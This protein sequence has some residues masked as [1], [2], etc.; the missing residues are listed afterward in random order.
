MPVVSRLRYLPLAVAGVM[1]GLT[2]CGGGNNLAD[3][4]KEVLANCTGDNC[5]VGQ[6]LDEPV[7]GLNY[8]CD[9][10]VSVTSATGTFSCPNNSVATFYLKAK[11]GKREIVL[12]SV[13]ISRIV[14]VTGFQAVKVLQITP[15]D[16]VDNGR[17][18]DDLTEPT[19][20]VTQII[21][22]LRFLQA[23]GEPASVFSG[24]NSRIHIPEERKVAIDQLENDFSFALFASSNFD[25]LIAPVLS[26]VVTG[27]VTLPTST[28]AI[29]RFQH[30]MRMVQA[31]VY[32]ASPQVFSG[33]VDLEKESLHDVGVVGQS[34]PTRTD[35]NIKS[36]D[37]AL[38][39][40]LLMLDR[41]GK[42]LGFGLEWLNTVYSSSANPEVPL[43]VS[44][45]PLKSNSTDITPIGDNLGFKMSGLIR[46]DFAFRVGA[47]GT[48]E[49]LGKVVITGG[50]MENGFMLGHPVFY[51][52]LFGLSDSE[53]VA[54][55]KI[56]KWTRYNASNVPTY[57]GNATIQRYRTL[58]PY[59]DPK[60]WK[61]MET[62][63]V[64]ERPVFP[65]HLRITMRNNKT[66]G[67]CGISGC[68]VGNLDFT[69]LA[70]GNI[71]SDINRD[72]SP[73]SADGS[74]RDGSGQQEYRLGAVAALIHEKS[75][76][77]VS[78]VMLVPHI[79][80]WESMYGTH[81]GMTS[82]AGGGKVKI[83]LTG[84]LSGAVSILDNQA[85]NSEAA[86]TWVNYINYYRFYRKYPTDLT[87]RIP[88]AQGKIS[89]IEL[90]SCYNP[91]VKS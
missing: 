24:S 29:E 43:S 77:F 89:N 1:A 71:V 27:G 23:M 72:C 51:R 61:T 70:N 79:P 4:V 62:V 64:G 21:N 45:L 57:T 65:L 76:D 35:G 84:V 63:P 75:V 37:K 85:E 59:L 73:L 9:N 78:P 49:N 74:Y 67:A 13:K 41:D 25:E 48:A 87:G 58:D 26:R 88:E 19:S 36:S 18:I 5:V 20:R 38:E 44:D 60:I 53:P 17:L 7:S 8:R 11:E 2:G 34:G 32:E 6:F 47:A 54:D 42:S 66:D 50:M 22:T 14:S 28:Q 86:A 40:F 69:I 39:G 82:S 91:P 46:P 55:S 31:G 56:G 33:F 83:S 3:P 12:G 30:S 52:N 81:I 90:Q 15:R 68:T 16:F 80:G 10:V